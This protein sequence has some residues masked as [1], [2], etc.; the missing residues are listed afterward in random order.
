MQLVSE[1]RRVSRKL[2]PRAVFYIASDMY[3]D[4]WKGGENCPQTVKEALNKAKAFLDTE[5]KQVKWF[6][7]YEF[8]IKQDSMGISGLADAAMCLK[9]DRFMYAVPSNFGRWIHEQR[10]PRNQVS[11][12]TIVNCTDPRFAGE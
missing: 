1:A 5:L 6:N 8:G 12:T 7:P 2:G 10:A 4:G 11:H 9:S 3:N